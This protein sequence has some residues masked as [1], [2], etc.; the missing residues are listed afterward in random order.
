MSPT[1]LGQGDDRP[2][3]NP[4]PTV[5]TK[6]WTNTWYDSVY[7]ADASGRVSRGGAPGLM[8]TPPDGL[9]FQRVLRTLPLSEWDLPDEPIR[10]SALAR[11]DSGVPYVKQVQLDD[12]V[13]MVTWNSHAGNRGASIEWENYRPIGPDFLQEYVTNGDDEGNIW[14]TAHGQAKSFLNGELMLRDEC[15]Y[16]LPGSGSAAGCERAVLNGVASVGVPYSWSPLS[17]TINEYHYED[18]CPLVP[19]SYFEYRVTGSAWWQQR[20]LV[21]IADRSSFFRP[22][23]NPTTGTG[24][25][26]NAGV[27]RWDPKQVRYRIP[28]PGDAA[29][30][31]G[32]SWNAY[33]EQMENF[34]GWS[35]MDGRELRGPDGFEDWLLDY[36]KKSWGEP[37]GDFVGPNADKQYP[38]LYAPVPFTSVGITGYWPAVP[39]S[40]PIDF[41]GPFS[42]LSEFVS[43]GEQPMYLVA[44]READEYLGSADLTGLPA[45]APDE[46]QSWCDLC[47]GDYDRNGIIGGE[48]LAILLTNWGSTNTCFTLDRSD[49]IING[50]DLALLLSNWQYQCEW[51][52]S[53]WRPPDCGY[54]LEP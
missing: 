16:E 27:P 54:L 50:N 25:E 47:P 30:G 44:I 46:P 49:P 22:S 17:Q 48:D 28:R 53:D 24:T 32:P 21:F 38:C 9:P 5:T 13:L 31:N 29:D 15:L 2:C 12:P 51:P 4:Q 37:S 1:S 8:H 42:A 18:P 3:P 19:R 41:M 14:V 26:D 35:A 7:R 52:L 34:V 20:L 6:D 10:F 39:D 43:V 11:D 40:G 23:F 45:P 33:L 36:R